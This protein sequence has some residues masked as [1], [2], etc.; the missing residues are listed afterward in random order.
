MVGIILFALFNLGW[1][2]L[3]RLV[4][5]TDID[6]LPG[7]LSQSFTKGNLLQ[8]FSGDAWDFHKELGQKYG[9]VVRINAVLGNKYLYVSDPHVLHHVI[10]KDQ[11]VFGKTTAGLVTSGILF[12]DGLLSTFGERH[13]KQRKML[14]P[15]F[16]TALM[17]E[18][19]PVF[20]EVTHKLSNAL[21]HKVENGLQ[22]IDILRWV[23]R[24]SLELV[25]QSGLG[26]SLDPLTDDLDV[27]PYSTAVKQAQSVIST[28]VVF[29][30]FLPKL[31]NFGSP[32]F[33]GFIVDILPFD[34]V[35]RLRD[36]INI[37][38]ETPREILEAK[39]RA[40]Q[41]GDE[42]VARQ[43]ARGQDII[44]TLMKGNMEAS[45]ED[46]LPES[47][48]RGQ[49]GTLMF[50]ATDTTSSAIS[51]TLHLLATHL[52]VQ[53]KLQQEIKG[54]LHN[55]GG[56]N[57]SYDE[58]VSLPFLN[59]VCR[60]TLRLYPPIALGARTANKETIMPL[61]TPITGVDGREMR[62]IV[63][64]KDT[65]IIISIL[66]CNCDPA[67]WGPDSYDWKPERWLSPL[68][69]TLTDVPIPGIYSHLMTF[70]GGGRSC[71]GFRFSQLEMK[72]VL[73]HLLSRFQFALSD[74]EISWEMSGVS[75]P[76]EKG[77]PGIPRMPLKVT[78]L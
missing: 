20:Y 33:R 50:A 76:T 8:T 41:E 42:A 29:Q 17:R 11:H 51:R 74:K 60:E 61:S 35:K 10:I 3:R 55:T 58:L 7:P 27:H 28:L 48:I 75:A 16:S 9:G 67:L 13:R 68:P 34:K 72:V 57:L 70:M 62:Q 65:T 25:A 26:C 23:T 39:K 54:A 19:V 71:I 56:Q 1:R 12:G 14:N 31:A 4:V 53:D 52:D 49:I 36:I 73:S 59:A 24:T 32:R 64:P 15:V 78:F 22:E 30:S 63:V 18:M 46:K 37:M 43:I 5:K 47:D 6:N 2:I 77:Q 21:G 69:D 66:N 45:E 38:H 44:S 40:L